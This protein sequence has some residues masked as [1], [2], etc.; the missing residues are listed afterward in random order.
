MKIRLQNWKIQLKKAGFRI[1]AAVAAIAEHSIARRYASGR[2][3]EKD[4]EELEKFAERISEKLVSGEKFQSRRYLE[5]RPYKKRGGKGMVPKA[6]S[7]KCVKC[8]VLCGKVPCCG[9]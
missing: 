9:Y 6:S 3:D 8:G 1:I 2:P 4:C 7:K 5:N